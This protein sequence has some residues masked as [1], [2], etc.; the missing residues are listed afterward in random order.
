M[1]PTIQVQI[2]VMNNVSLWCYWTLFPSLCVDC[3]HDAYSS[4]YVCEAGTILQ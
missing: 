1:V 4:D 2:V 3:R